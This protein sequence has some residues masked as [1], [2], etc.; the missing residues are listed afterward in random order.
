MGP[1][2]LGDQKTALFFI[3]SNT[4]SSLNFLIA[5]AFTQLFDLQCK[6][7]DDVYGGRLPVQ[8]QSQ[9]K[10]LYKD[11]A[12]TTIGNMDAK[13]FLG[14]SETS[15]LK[16]WSAM[17]GKQSIDTYNTSDTRGTSRSYGVNYQKLGRELL[18]PDELATMDAT[19]PA[20]GSKPTV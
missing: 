18:T 3:I 5:M 14:G 17:L 20:N 2:T 4:D 13:I 12:E 11:N 6:K 7:A 16:D 19:E 1:D 15:T 10:A 8:A 9:L